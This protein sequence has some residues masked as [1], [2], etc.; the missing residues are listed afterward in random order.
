[1]SAFQVSPHAVSARYRTRFTALGVLAIAGSWLLY[2]FGCVIALAGL[3]LFP[4]C[5]PVTAMYLVAG[6]SLLTTAY[7]YAQT[8]AVR[9]PIAARRSDETLRPPLAT[10]VAPLPR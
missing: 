10:P 5:A 8:H 7:A 4:P 6:A 1:M 9:V 2:L 3:F